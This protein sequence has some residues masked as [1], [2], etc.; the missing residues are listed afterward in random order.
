MCGILYARLKKDA[1]Q[2]AHTRQVFAAAL[3][4]V[5]YRG[6]DEKHIT[7]YQNHLFGHA[8]L[9]IIDPSPASQ[10][11]ME[12]ECGILA[13][14]GEIYNY[15]NLDPTATSDTRVLFNLFTRHPQ[16]LPTIRGMYAAVFLDKRT[17]E[18]HFMRDYYGEKPLYVFENDQLHIACSSL[19]PIRYLLQ[20]LLGL[21]PEISSAAI[22]DYLLFGFIR[23]PLTV[24]S[25]ITTVPANG[26][27]II[28]PHG[29]V[30]SQNLLKT[31]DLASS[32][33]LPQSVTAT[34][35]TPVLLLSSGVDSTYV[36][37]EVEGAG[38]NCEVAV[39]AHANPTL[40]ESRQAL[41]N[42]HKIAPS[43]AAHRITNTFTLADIHQTHARL[44]EQPSIDGLDMLNVLTGLKKLRP[45]TRL[46]LTGMGGDELY[47]GYH[48]FHRLQYHPY[49]GI[50][51]KLLGGVI[52]GLKRF[53]ITLPGEK[54]HPVAAYYFKYRLDENLLPL[55]SKEQ[56]HQR[57]WA[58]VQHI[59][60]PE[61]ATALQQLKTLEVTDYLKNQLLR[62]TDNIAMYLGMEARS[63]LL[64]PAAMEAKVDFKVAMK[65]KVAMLH[66]VTFGP[67]QGFNYG[68]DQTEFLFLCQQEFPQLLTT[69]PQ[70]RTITETLLA[71]KTVPFQSVKKLFMLLNWL[72]VNA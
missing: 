63:P 33:Y 15:T 54:D 44:L 14:N 3:D 27:V 11:P 16:L 69:Y 22:N 20:E 35:V 6:P 36:L 29:V 66:N 45:A 55:V 47:G 4:L 71:Q 13:F 43:R 37:S 67:K 51:A 7:A 38:L 8:R 72:R 52:P 65:N 49:L 62:D 5:S 42:L 12:D 61:N 23:E 70:F 50:A 57:F 48:S 30:S 28:G 34:D 17:D 19:K 46:V 40:D 58:F 59:Q 32:N 9:A 64:T 26:H 24:Y 1:L 60:Y 31:P 39:Y 68:E 18:V 25:G 10:Q 2:N 53:G 21:S 41:E 56:L